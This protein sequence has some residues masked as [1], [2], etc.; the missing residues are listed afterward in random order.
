MT[1]TTAYVYEIRE[2]GKAGPLLAVAP[3]MKTMGR[4]AHRTGGYVV[5][6]EYNPK[7]HD[8]LLAKAR[9]ERQR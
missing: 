5:L 7:T 1:K 6:A 3:D 9:E 2:G 4:D 8:E